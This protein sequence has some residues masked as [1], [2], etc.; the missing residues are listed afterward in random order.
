MRVLKVLVIVLLVLIAAAFLAAG[1]GTNIPLLQYGGAKAYGL[2]VGGLFLIAAVL[3]AVFWDVSVT[4]TRIREEETT[5]DGITKIKE[6]LNT[7]K[8]LNIPPQ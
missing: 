2:P 8:R 1:L 6:T 5:K 3:L 7:I 4:T